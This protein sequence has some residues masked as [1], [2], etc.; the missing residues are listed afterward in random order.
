MQRQ[1]DKS[2]FWFIC[3]TQ[4]SGQ[5]ARFV[6]SVLSHCSCSYMMLYLNVE[7][8]IQ[9]ENEQYFAHSKQLKWIWFN[10]IAISPP[11]QAIV[12]FL[13]AFFSAKNLRTLGETPKKQIGRIHEFQTH[14]D[15]W[16]V[17]H[18]PR[19]KRGGGGNRSH[20]TTLTSLERGMAGR[21]TPCSATYG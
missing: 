5:D 9:N 15:R 8:N 6:V 16:S 17:G 7:T 14:H 10:S 18:P 21:R 1:N 4:L 2:L 19:W 11:K 13:K 3:A 20:K 12:W